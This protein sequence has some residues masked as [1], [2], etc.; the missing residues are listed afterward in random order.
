MNAIRQTPPEFAHDPT[1]E[2]I[3]FAVAPLRPTPLIVISHGKPFGIPADA[4]G[5]SPDIL[6]RAW[7][8]A[9]NELAVLVP[10]ARQVIAAE[11]APYVQ[12][13]QPALVIDAIAQVV[14]AVRTS[15]SWATPTSG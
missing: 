15:A 10:N 7:S 2:T 3:D 8:Q 12:L 13:D 5:F 4:L 1:Y 9:Q 14:A 6:E 11:S